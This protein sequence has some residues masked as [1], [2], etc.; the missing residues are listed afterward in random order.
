MFIDLLLSHRNNSILCNTFLSLFVLLIHL[1]PS[2]LNQGWHIYKIVE[3]V[4][5]TDV[6]VL[7]LSKNALQIEYS[8]INTIAII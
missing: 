6:V 2:P 1:V 5:L 7:V 8:L 3:P 4:I